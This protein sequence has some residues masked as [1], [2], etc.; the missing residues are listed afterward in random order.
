[1][2]VEVPPVGT[3]CPVPWTKVRPVCADLLHGAPTAVRARGAFIARSQGSAVVDGTQ[4]DSGSGPASLSGREEGRGQ[5]RWEG[6]VPITGL[7]L[8]EHDVPSTVDPLV[9][10]PNAADGRRELGAELT[11]GI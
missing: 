4:A 11:G 1:M 7:T 2:R 10:R 3:E 6:A 5:G 8:L 9:Q